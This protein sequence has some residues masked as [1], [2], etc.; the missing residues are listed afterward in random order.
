[1]GL[2]QYIQCNN[3]EISDSLAGSRRYF[4]LWT[5]S[6]ALYRTL[7]RMAPDTIR[8]RVLDAGAGR[9]AYRT[10]L[11]AHAETIETLDIQPWGGRTDHVAD[12]QHMPLADATY[13]SVFCTQVL[14]HLPEPGRALAEI[15]RILKPGGDALIS[16]P[17]LSWLHN[18]PHDYFRFT[19]HGLRHMLSAAG[20]EEVEIRPV[21]GLLCFLGF[22]PTTVVLGLVWRPRLLFWLF[23]PINAIFVRLC[24]ALD[25]LLGAKQLFP[26]NYVVQARKPV[27]QRL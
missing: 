27:Q 24:L 16:V 12:I 5:T 3:R 7:V 19:I 21:G 4:T 13:D 22:I 11:A 18:E 20:L 8:G 10:L 17:H 6:L 26:V 2:L 14:H 23:L 15:A 25:S 1:M 9:Q